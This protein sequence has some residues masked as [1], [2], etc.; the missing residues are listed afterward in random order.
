MMVWTLLDYVL[1]GDVIIVCSIAHFELEQY[2]D[3]KKAFAKG[4]SVVK[5]GNDLLEK[6]FQTWLRK[7]DAEMDSTFFK[8]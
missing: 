5:K 3:A 7:C 4:K 8:L 2:G 6:R 1:C